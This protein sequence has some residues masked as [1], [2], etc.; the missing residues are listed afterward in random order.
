MNIPLRHA[1]SISTLVGCGGGGSG[2][3]STGGGDESGVEH[4]SVALTTLPCLIER[5]R[6]VFSTRQ[7]RTR[8]FYDVELSVEMISGGGKVQSVR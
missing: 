3:W 2:G 8:L 7:R 4:V 6:N 5:V 1:K